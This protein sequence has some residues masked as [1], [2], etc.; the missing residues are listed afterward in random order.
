MRRPTTTHA[1]RWAAAL[2]L[3]ALLAGP[4]AAQDPPSDDGGGISEAGASLI[5]G[6]AAFNRGDYEEAAGHFERAAAADPESG[7]AH[8]WLGVTLLALGRTAEAERALEAALAAGK[9][10]RAGRQRVRADLER[11]RSAAEAVVVAAPGLAEA[12]PFGDVPT[13]EIRLSAGAGDDD[14]PLRL[15]D[16]SF[17]FYRLPNG[18]FLDGPVSDSLLRANVRAE[19]RPVVDRNGWTLTLGG[20]VDEARYDDFDFLD[21]RVL[22]ATAQLAWGGDPV[23]Y[24]AGPLGSSRVPLRREPVAFLVQVRWQ[25]A[26]LDGEGFLTSVGAAASATVNEGRGMATRLSAGWNDHDYDVDQPGTFERSGSEVVA[27]V[28]QVFYFGRR[29]R[30]LTV[31][32]ESRERD[33]GPAF[34]RSALELR[35]SLALP[36]GSSGALRLGAAREDVEFDD[37]A[38]NPFFGFFFADRVREDTVD[39]LSAA[40]TWAATPRLLLTVGGAWSERDTELGPAVDAFLDLD[41]ERTVVSA[42]VSWYLMGGGGR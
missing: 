40:L 4:A 32:V 10:P 42:G 1:A 23:G 20:E 7:D 30:F 2:L 34:D 3:G 6:V 33:A 18:D 29:D 12:R 27:A 8:H 21:T 24:L 15:T 5:F 39:R 31:G 38:S 14:N 16:D 22:A 11:A 17:L 37:L 35:G 41:Y 28:D 36:F 9:P 13:W 25:N 19:V 26:E